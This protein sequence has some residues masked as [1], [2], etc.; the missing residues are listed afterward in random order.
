MAGHAKVNNNRVL[1]RVL[2]LV[3]ASDDKKSSTVMDHVL[4]FF[5]ALDE[6]GKWEIVR[7]DTAAVKFK[8]CRHRI[9]RPIVL[10]EERGR[11]RCFLL[12]TFEG[13]KSAIYL[14]AIFL[15]NLQGEA[16]WRLLQCTIP[17]LGSVNE[18][19]RRHSQ[20]KIYHFRLGKD[21]SRTRW[22]IMLEPGVAY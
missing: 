21:L 20:V 13:V 9:V 16:F 14:N 8:L 6:A 2:S 17:H 12:L 18:G 7:A 22:L 10:K 3:Y 4:C 1:H 15:G 5:K 11:G 19:R